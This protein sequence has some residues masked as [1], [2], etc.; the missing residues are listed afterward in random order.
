[1][2]PQT[3]RRK[4]RIHQQPSGEEDMGA[5]MGKVE[6]FLRASAVLMLVLTAC[7]VGTDTQTKAIVYTYTKKATFKALNALT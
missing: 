4:K 3:C 1:M 7:L 6:A 5:S 2:E